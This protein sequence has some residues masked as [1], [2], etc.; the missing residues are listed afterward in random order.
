M[1]RLFNPGFAPEI[2]GS[3]ISTDLVAAV[4]CLAASSVFS[5]ATV[6]QYILVSFWGI[7]ERLEA[8]REWFTL[9]RNFGDFATVRKLEML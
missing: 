8:L 4:H 7:F 6:V 9:T 5:I 2:P 1:R 3:A